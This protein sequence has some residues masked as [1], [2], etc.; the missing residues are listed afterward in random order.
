MKTKLHKWLTEALHEYDN[1]DPRIEINM[2]SWADRGPFFA[3]NALCKSCLAGLVFIKAE[4]GLDKWLETTKD[5]SDLA[6]DSDLHLAI[7]ALN[8]LRTGR[9]QVACNYWYRRRH[10]ACPEKEVHNIEVMPHSVNASVWREQ[11]NT[12]LWYLQQHDL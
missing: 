11:M 9:I 1:H 3:T 8:A 4:G 2:D 12:V 5:I 7:F 6:T 10:V